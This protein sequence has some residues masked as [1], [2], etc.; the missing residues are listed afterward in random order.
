[1]KIYMSNTYKK[2]FHWPLITIT[3][4]LINRYPYPKPKLNLCQYNFAKP[5][6]KNNFLVITHQYNSEEG[7][8]LLFNINY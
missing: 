2:I 1:M 8:N 7:S 3:T 4:K 6:V 5:N